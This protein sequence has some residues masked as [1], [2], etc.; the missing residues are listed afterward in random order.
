MERS[1]QGVLL[2]SGEGGVRWNA[3]SRLDGRCCCSGGGAWFWYTST[4][5]GGD[6]ARGVIAERDGGPGVRGVRPA[7]RHCVCDAID[8]ATDRAVGARTLLSIRS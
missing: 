4:P 8:S 2:A 1:N 6:A 3:H 5:G 7:R